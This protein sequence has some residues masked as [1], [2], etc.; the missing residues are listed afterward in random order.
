MMALPVTD[1]A[2]ATRLASGLTVVTQ[3]MAHLATAFVGVWI[4]AGSRSE[5][6][7]QHGL[8]HLLEHMAFKGTTRRTARDIAEE[9]EAVGG[10]LNAATSTEQTGFT[11]HV[12]AEH[13]P[14]AIDILSDIVLHSTF[15]DD[16]LKRETNVILQEI[17]AVDD[18]PDD[19]IY[20]VFLAT[21]FPGQTLGRSILGTTKTVSALK[22][23]DLRDFLSTW[24]RP[25]RLV[26]VAVGAVDHGAIVDMV[27][28]AFE[29]PVM[30]HQSPAPTEPARYVGGEAR[31]KRR[32]EQAHIV[33]GLPGIGLHDPASD[34]AQIFALAFGGGVSSRLFQ[35]VREERGLA[36]S[37]D[38]FHWPFSDAGIFG[39]G[40]GASGRDLPEL[41]QVSLDALS[42]A[43]RDLTQPEL[44]RARAQMRMG[45]AAGLESPAARAEQL[46]RHI[47]QFN[48]IVPRAEIEGRIAGVD[49]D[50]ARAAGAAIAAGP[51]TMAAIGPIER[52]PSLATIEGRLRAA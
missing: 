48:R 15:P 25:E 5:S 50:A 36:Y 26:V 24:Y 52:L 17:G 34:A 49:L 7:R 37:I 11:A 29:Q 31:M 19:L 1:G 21:A 38:A 9:I 13:V 39:I 3:P 47:L 22:G 23:D 45:L 42:A 44:D 6:D 28:R 30:P 10:D 46:A 8:A 27:A 41:V 16:E 20:D 12:L 18:T 32:L 43:A 2:H 51:L 14:M 35:H 33:L 4:G 40:A